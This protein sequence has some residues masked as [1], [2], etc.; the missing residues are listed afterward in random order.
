MANRCS[1]LM[2]GGTLI[3]AP[4]A[5][6]WEDVLAIIDLSIA[7]HAESTAAMVTDTVCAL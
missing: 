5:Q 3:T 1:A 4:N 7:M 6:A 2:M